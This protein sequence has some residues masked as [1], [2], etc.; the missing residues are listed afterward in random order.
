[1]ETIDEAKWYEERCKESSK[2][3]GQV[4]SS[5]EGLF[6]EVSCNATKIMK[7]LREKGQVTD[8]NL[9]QIFGGSGLPIF[10]ES[11]NPSMVGVGRALCGSSSP[12]VLP[13]QG[14]LQ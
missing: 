9:M 6:R 14:H 3:L 8:L 4:K 13:K 12:T 10:T 7:Q 1:M 2:V 5:M 11:Q